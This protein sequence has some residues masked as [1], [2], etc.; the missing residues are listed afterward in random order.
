MLV[1]ILFLGK[2]HF[3]KK[4]NKFYVPNANKKVLLYTVLFKKI[5]V[6]YAIK[7]FLIRR[8]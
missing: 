4:I 3:D 5:I 8:L 6:H 2:A 7:Y 1:G